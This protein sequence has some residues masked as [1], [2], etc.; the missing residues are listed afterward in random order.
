MRSPL[1]IRPAYSLHAN[2]HLPL[3]PPNPSKQIPA[4]SSFIQIGIKRL[5]QFSEV[6][7]FCKGQKQVSRITKGWNS[8]AWFLNAA[9]TK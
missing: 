7:K 9:F 8:N 1:A 6:P 4:T 5:V 2:W 3:L